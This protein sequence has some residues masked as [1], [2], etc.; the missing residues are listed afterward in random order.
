[1]LYFMSKLYMEHFAF[2]PA[3]FK[4]INAHVTLSILGVKGHNN[5]YFTDK[6]S[7]DRY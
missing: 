3:K 6:I 7:K 4:K 2:S 5:E 1:M